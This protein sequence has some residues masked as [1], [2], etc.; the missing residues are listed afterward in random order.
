MRSGE[1]RR[2]SL[3][4][5]LGL[6][7]LGGLTQLAGDALAMQQ[8]GERPPRPRR[9]GQPGSQKGTTVQLPTFGISVDAD[10]VL[11]FKTW[12]DPTGQLHM[13][14]LRAAQAALAPNIMQ[15][16]P[17]RI[18]SLRKLEAAIAARQAEGRGPTDEMAN[19]A[20]L[21]RVQFAFC[22][23]NPDN[24]PESD[25][26]LAGPAEGWMRN[27]ADQPVGVNTGRPTVQLVDLVTAL[28]AF[29][30]GGKAPP[31]VGCSIG[32]T[33]SGLKALSAF[34]AQVPA[35]IRPEQEAAVGAWVYQ[36]MREA[37]GLAT[38]SVYGVPETTHF[39]QVL[40]EADYRMKM[41]G[42]GLEPPGIKLNSYADL[43]SGARH[44][45]L[46]RWWFYPNY[47]MAKV[48]QDRLA[49]ELVGQGVLLSSQDLNFDATGKLGGANPGLSASDRFTRGFTNKFEEL[50]NVKPVFAQL[51]NLIDLTVMAAYL[52]RADFYG[53]A[54]WQPGLLADEKQ[55]TVEDLNAPRKV[56][57]AA[58]ALWKS[59]RLFVMAGGGVSIQPEIALDDEHRLA[60]DGSLDS[61]RNRVQTSLGGPADRWWWDQ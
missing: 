17:L 7:L 57:V 16:S 23:P 59:H 49:L 32:P 31:L 18:I 14:R 13:Q 12:E 37:L 51:R 54:D 47:E 60:D 3:R 4:L 48:S 1:Q 29:P 40:V 33:E 8:G 25:I 28:R 6:M 53:Q 56:P 45:V 34:Q 22:Y 36:G 58:N 9:G 39:G 43:I 38:I 15:D 2:F 52:Q 10:G 20:G 11:E 30:P 55:L 27:L 42:V 35:R 26:V 41:I 21:Q 46:Q 5:A 24:P 19:L 44:G 61:A 50:A